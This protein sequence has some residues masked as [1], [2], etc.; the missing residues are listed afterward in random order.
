VPDSTG[1]T[2]GRARQRAVAEGMPKP[3]PDVPP[4]V[5]FDPPPVPVGVGLTVRLTGTADPGIHYIWSREEND[6]IETPKVIYTGMQVAVAGGQPVAGWETASQWASWSAEVI[7][8]GAGAQEATVTGLTSGGRQVIGR[9]TLQ[10]Q[11]PV[12]RLL[13][14]QSLQVGQGLIAPPGGQDVRCVMQ[15]DGNFVVYWG[16][17]V[18]FPVWATHTDGSGAVD[19]VMQTDGNFV[20]YTAAQVPV[21]ASGTAGNPGAYL[22]MQPDGDLV[23][24]DAADAPIWRSGSVIVTTPPRASSVLP[25][26][27]QLNP[28]QFLQAPQQPYT[29]VMQSDG[30]LVVYKLGSDVLWGTG[31]AG[32][33]AA[34]AIM[35]GDGNLVLYTA[36]Q[37][38]VWA[39]DTAGNPGAHLAMQ[40]DGNLVI[41]RADGRPVW[42]SNTVQPPPS[43]YWAIVLCKFADISAERKPIGWYEDYYGNPAAGGA[44]AYWQTVTNG[45]VDISGSPVFG[46]FT[47]THSTTELASMSFPG[48]RW[49]L[50]QWGRDTAQANGVD[51]SKFKQVVTVMNFSCDSGAVGIPGDVV[52]GHG[53]PRYTD[54]GFVCHEMGHGFGL[55]HSWAANPDQ[56]YGDGF[57][58]MS[59]NTTTFDFPEVVEGVIGWATVGLNAHNL[60]ALGALGPVA[61]PTSSSDYSDPLVLNA[62]TQSPRILAGA[63]TAFQ[64]PQADGSVYQVEARR[65]AQWDRAIP[66]DNV[67][68]I[69]QVRTNGLCYLVPHAGAYFTTGQTFTTPDPLVVVYVGAPNG[70]QMQI[71]VWDLPDGALRQEL[72]DPRVY[73]IQGG[74]K[75]WV[76][77]QATLQLI[78]ETTGRIVRPV[79][80]GGLGSVATGP[81]IA[82]LDVTTTPHPPPLD[83]PVEITVSAT[84]PVTQAPVTGEVLIAGAQA[85]TTGTP[86]SYTFTDYPQA[87]VVAAGYVTTPIDFGFPPPPVVPNVI[88]DTTSDALKAIRAAGLVTSVHSRID[89]T[90]D[91]IG[92]VIS[93]SPDGG[94][95]SQPGAVVTIW[96][97]ATPPHGCP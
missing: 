77:N 37:V 41:Y 54:P 81:Y 78:Q 32:K 64:I 71:W 83:I 19:A 6:W 20:L 52:I 30:S 51:L 80:A 49:K 62:L 88:G 46:W 76:V 31:T 94:T 90:C 28:G 96:V 7:F 74:Q 67:V 4:T 33:G 69:N 95:S 56:E 85:G 92:E 84:D 12:D 34:F 26:G 39:S 53:D 9:V 93:Q 50:A 18:F 8:S 58:L 38:P 72:G 3:P 43:P 45:V 82:A 36:A 35:Q 10:V 68:I 73:L 70:D 11:T 22:V 27:A 47:M 63:F 91:H 66:A 60:E 86:F 29:C 14:G 42:A 97:G 89:G 15:T 48:D 79:P 16:G 5:I 59:F 1:R 55:V 61:G 57:D 13:P 2:E 23:I 24:F 25:A 17:G 21:W 75:R 44:T 40:D 87:V 65:K